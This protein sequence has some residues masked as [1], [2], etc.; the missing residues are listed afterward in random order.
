MTCTSLIG[1]LHVGSPVITAVRP[2][3]RSN[4]EKIPYPPGS[5]FYVDVLAAEFGVTRG[6]IWTYC[7]KYRDQLEPPC[8]RGTGFHRRRTF[9]EQD[10]KTFRSLFV[11]YVKRYVKR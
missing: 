2:K 6:T 3:K 4:Y 11:L 5:R 9:S 8:Y 7:W 10:R 1:V